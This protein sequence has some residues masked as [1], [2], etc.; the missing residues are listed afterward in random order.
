[1]N[2]ELTKNYVADDEVLNKQWHPTKN[3]GLSAQ[4][5]TLGSGRK[6]W[7]ICQRNHEWQATV[8]NRA[9]GVGCPY[10]AGKKVL[11]GYNDLL[12]VHPLIAKEWHPTNN[13][14][15]TAQN[16]M[17]GSNKKIWWRC[18]KGHEWQASV[19][20]RTCGSK[21]P[22]CAGKKVLAGYND[23]ATTHPELCKQWH[24][25]KNGKLTFNDI[26]FGS[27]RKV[28]W[29]CDKGHEWQAAMQVRNRG[30]GCPYCRGKKVLAGYNDL[31]TTY[32]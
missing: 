20:S 10:C 26:S 1:M 19:K 25:T 21:C 15:L 4:K 22:Y 29:R 14:E 2:V 6:V 11:A 3:E 32:P 8:N 30:V 9:K 18:D 28:W 13:G 16:V 31:A 7:W 27:Q 17:C 5:V 23:L 24:P 12:T